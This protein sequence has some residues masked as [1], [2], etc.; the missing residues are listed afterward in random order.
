MSIKHIFDDANG[1]VE[2]GLYGVAATNPAL[3]VE[4]DASHDR[5]K[6]AIL[7][8]GGAGHEPTFGGM[9]GRGMLSVAVSGDVFASPSAAQICSGVDLAPT[10]KGIIVVVLNYTGDCL[11]FGLASEKAR[12]A[13]ASEGKGKEVEMVIVGDDVSVGRSKGGLVGRRGLAGT[14]FVVK[15]LG[16]GSENGMDVKSLAKLGRTMVSNL[17]TV[18]SSL[19]HCHVPGRSTDDEERGALGPKAVEIGMGIHNEPGVKHIEEKPSADDLIK[20][21][22][23]LLLKEDDPERS[24]VKFEKDDDPVL[25]INNLGGMSVLE[26]TAVT[27]VVKE[28]LARDWNLKPVRV[29]C[30]TYTT[31]LNA[32]GFGITLLNHKRVSKEAGVDV[33]ELIDAPTDAP[34]WAGVV[35]GWSDKPVL[36][37]NDEQLKES[38]KLVNSKRESGHAVSGSQSGGKTAT[39]GPKNGDESKT[40]KVVE[41]LCQAVIDVEPTLT[42][43]DTVVGDG[44][45]GE[46]LRHA[47]EAIQK[48][49]KDGK[50]KTDYATATV[51]SITEVLESVMG[52]TS[53]AIY[54]IYL[55][56]LV[57]GLLKSGEKTSDAANAKHWGEAA[58]HALESLGKYTPA[59]PGDRTLVDALDP[60]CRTLL[61][62]TEGGKG[63]KE[64]LE[65]AVKAAKEGAE[66]TRELTARLGRATYVGETSEKVPDPGAWGVWALVEGILKAL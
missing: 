29:Y 6:V 42:K 11:N 27:S 22:L 28:Q 43:Y 19:D 62:A 10:D 1:L 53:G 32:P 24:F 47:A 46:T 7:A 17:V 18:G 59:R 8:G 3:R 20:E 66:H 23:S 30:S 16:A 52:G 56:G 40:K 58:V 38:E 33:L 50:V 55:T 35:Q 4:R 60:F 13:F 65:E 41:S 5:S 36:L 9:T 25:I 31:S 48:A 51:L 57:Q 39:S 37:S 44:D 26:L 61:K 15:A 2:K 49:L 21:M 34:G 14:P 45:A 64:A 63:D 54:Q 12:S